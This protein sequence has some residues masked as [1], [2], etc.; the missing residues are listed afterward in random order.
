MKKGRE[1][2]LSPSGGLLG[3]TRIQRTFPWWLTDL[4]YLRD[5]VISAS[6]KPA[7]YLVRRTD[8]DQRHSEHGKKAQ[9]E[10]AAHVAK[11]TPPGHLPLEP[12]PIKPVD[13]ADKWAG[14]S[15]LGS[16]YAVTS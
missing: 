7:R 1:Q 4:R 12:G 5:G 2:A 16:S 3:I 6:P 11:S 9:A 13:P 15:A 10:G 14:S 8:R